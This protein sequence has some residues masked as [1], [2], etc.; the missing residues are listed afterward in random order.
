MLSDRPLVRIHVTRVLLSG[1]S[2]LDLLTSSQVSYYS[3]KS[4]KI[5]VYEVNICYA[6]CVCAFVRME[7]IYNIPS[8]P[9]QS[10]E[11]VSVVM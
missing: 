1:M 2:D 5:Q 6:V 9:P 7:A 4:C 10:T 8:E 3:S 11:V